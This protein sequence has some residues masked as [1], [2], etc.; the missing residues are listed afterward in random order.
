MHSTYMLSINCSKQ[1]MSTSVCIH[2][3]TYN[4]QGHVSQPFPICV[5][6]TVPGPPPP[7]PAP[8]VCECACFQVQHVLQIV[9]SMIRLHLLATNYARTIYVCFVVVTLT[10]ELSFNLHINTVFIQ[11]LF[12]CHP[13]HPLPH[14]HLLAH[15][16]PALLHVSYYVLL[17]VIALASA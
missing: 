5:H 16:H 12:P 14:L 13:Q 15:F 9:T 8:G 6:S 3:L 10:Q 4:F 2:D 11:F 1:L 7:F 17:L